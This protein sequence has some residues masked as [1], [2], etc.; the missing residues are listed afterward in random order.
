MSLWWPGE[1]DR[2]ISKFEDWVLKR[3]GYS[4]LQ[5]A[6]LSRACQTFR[7]K[8]DPERLVCT[9]YSFARTQ[10]NSCKYGRR[11]THR[12]SSVEITDDICISEISDRC[13]NSLDKMERILK[14]Y[15]RAF[16]KL[17]R[18]GP[19]SSH[20]LHNQQL[21]ILN[22]EVIQNMFLKCYNVKRGDQHEIATSRM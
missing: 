15:E 4:K 19:T 5:T 17:P 1:W 20:Y 16:A 11:S 3:N 7:Y 9:T 14:Q 6:Q 18:R 21:D 2:L 10:P 22:E 8:P 12:P 13:L